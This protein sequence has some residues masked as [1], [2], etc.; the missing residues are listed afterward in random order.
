MKYC[1]TLNPSYS[2]NL[3]DSD[4][5][6]FIP[7]ECLTNGSIC[8]KTDV[9]GRVK[10]GYTFFADGDIIMAKVT[11]CFENGNIAIVHNLL[12]GVGFGTSEL[13]VFRS[14]TIDT[15]YLFYY[16]QNDQF[17]QL[18]I[19]TMYGTGGL[20]RVSL[21]FIRNYTFYVPPFAKQQQI[22]SFLDTKCSLIDS[23]IEKER[24][25]IEKLKEY[26]QAVITEAVTKGIR[27]GVLMKDSGVE[28]IGEIPE[29]W[30]VFR[31]KYLL[32]ECEERSLNGTEEPLSMSQKYGIIKSSD[33]DIPNPASSYV[34]GKLVFEED[35]VFNKLKAHLGVFSLSKYMGVV[36]PDYA[37]YHGINDTNAK[38]LEYLFKTGKCI[39]EFKKYIRGV[40]A[41]LSRL[42]TSDL[43]NIKVAIPL[44]DE[45]QLIVEFLNS[46]CSD[47]DATI[48]KRELA[49]E[50]LTAYK[51]S[52]IYECVTGKKEVLA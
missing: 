14:K 8:P 25:V 32:T 52:L 17:K 49:I 40:G 47:I 19:G 16:L 24:E 20:K 2:K 44:C 4:S 26:R 21:D 43:F 23:T 11:P 18:C 37:V 13:Y 5:I 29:G 15:V 48:Q 51:Q 10:T 34:G 6:S 31:V 39:C 12:N 42:Y 9:V 41:G 46:K 30:D 7:M 28:W 36:S 27:P 22:A 50:K 45:Q 38:F 35:L 33:L 1:V 3:N